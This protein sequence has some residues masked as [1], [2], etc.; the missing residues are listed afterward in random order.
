MGTH[1]CERCSTAITSPG[2]TSIA[3]SPGAA[4]PG[5]LAVRASASLVIKRAFSFAHLPM[6]ASVEQYSQEVFGTV[7]DF[8]HENPGRMFDMLRKRHLGIDDLLTFSGEN[9][10]E[11]LSRGFKDQ[12]YDIFRMLPESVLAWLLSG[13]DSCFDC[14]TE[15]SAANVSGSL[16]YALAEEHSA[17][18]CPSQPLHPLWSTSHQHQPC[19]ARRVSA[20]IQTVYATRVVRCSRTG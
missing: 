15:A 9:V 16:L 5:T 6:S 3:W 18:S 10:D 7:L 1:D 12:I 4:H 14:N 20:P 19:F 8:L 13:E 17:P 11:K 2:A